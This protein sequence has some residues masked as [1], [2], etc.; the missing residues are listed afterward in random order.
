MPSTRIET[1]DWAI[2]RERDVI[3]AVQAALAGALE[4]PEWDREVVKIKV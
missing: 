4:L 1:G 3:E 2:G